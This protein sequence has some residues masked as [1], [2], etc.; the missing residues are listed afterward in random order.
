MFR[1]AQLK[2]F[3]TITSILIA[4]FII[5]LVSIN[6]VTRNFMQ[7]QSEEVLQTI[8]SGI[9]YDEKT[10]T[11]SFTPPE[12]YDRKHNQNPPFV[13]TK[14]PATT[15]TTTEIPAESETT[16]EE[17]TATEEIPEETTAIIEEIIPDPPDTEDELSDEPDSEIQE[18]DQPDTQPEE[19][20]SDTPENTEPP[21]TENPPPPED[22]NENEQ[23]PDFPHEDERRPE[24]FLHDDNHGN[25]ERWWHS[26]GWKFYNPEEDNIFQQS[27]TENN[28]I[29][30]QLENTAENPPEK[31][32]IDDIP[33]DMKTEPVPKSFG[34][35]DFFVI[36]ADNKG[37]YLACMNNDDL[38]DENA[39]AYITEI[40]SHKENTGMMD[41][42]QFYN[43]EKNNGTLI[44]LTDKSEESKVMKQFIRTTIIIGALTL[45]VLSFAGYFLSKKSIE[46]IKTAFEKQKQFISDAS[47]ELKTPL[48]VI[49]ANADVLSGEIGENKWLNYIKSQTDRMNLLVNDLLN[50]TRLE[51]NT[52]N[53]ICTDFNLSQAV[54]NT[55]LPFECRAFETN[56]KFIVDVEEGLTV[57]GSEQHI[58]QMTAI[59]I[60]NALKYSNDNGM[61]RVSLKKQGDKKV[62]SVYNTGQGVKDDE[63][64]KIFERFYRTDDS[65]TRLAT[66]GYGLGLAIAKSIIDKHKFKITVDNT[67]GKSIC[68]IITM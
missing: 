49:S 53:F 40:L 64:E 48:T 12:N 11:F 39:Q 31:K 36:M 26:D 30:L 14:P 20:S 22:W 38:T 54:I 6:I 15:A 62:L 13:K 60:D 10:D 45:I 41:S 8:A 56:K 59:F 9:E 35:I 2:L 68:F 57:N 17:T 44:A 67:E 37:N 47:H 24:D 63:K 27:F 66:G 52:S 46:P 55:A 58:K 4:I 3:S 1:K 16:T 42:Y 32:R 43:I 61:V 33:D 23:M 28:N 21:Q 51:N 34:S 25:P 65:R 29:T 50:L 7:R 5:V 19:I 18:E